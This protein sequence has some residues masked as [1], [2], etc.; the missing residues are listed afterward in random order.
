M[1]ASNSISRILQNIKAIVGIVLFQETG[2]QVQSRPDSKDQEGN[3]GN[4]FAEPLA[5]VELRP[6]RVDG[7][8]E[9]DDLADE[10]PQDPDWAG[11][12]EHQSQENDQNEEAESND[13]QTLKQEQPNLTIM[14]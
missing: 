8:D 14:I 3:G 4:H 13:E 10:E 5:E 6:L 2:Q 12:R 7:D 1:N 11:Q 9:V